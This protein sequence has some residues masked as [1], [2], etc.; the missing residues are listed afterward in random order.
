MIYNGINIRGVN[1]ERLVKC[2]PPNLMSD[3]EKGRISLDQGVVR[4]EP[5]MERKR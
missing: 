4:R 1:D 2:V 3:R 5:P